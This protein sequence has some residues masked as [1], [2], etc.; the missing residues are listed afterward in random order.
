MSEELNAL[1]ASALDLYSHAKQAHWN[2]RGVEFISIHELFDK[3]SQASLDHADQLAERAGQLGAEVAGTLRKAA[4]ASRLPEYK[5]GIA[6]CPEHIEQLAES[7]ALFGK[8]TLRG[9]EVA[10]EQEDPVTADILTRI[11]G[12]V[13]KLL[14]FVESHQAPARAQAAMK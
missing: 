11:C 8:N 7:M 5:L 12:E 2:V 6:S 14:W 3:V 13:D 1:L 9:I 4:G 10:Q